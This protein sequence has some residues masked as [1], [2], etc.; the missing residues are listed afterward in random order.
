MPFAVIM[1]GCRPHRPNVARMG[2]RG[3]ATC[4]SDTRPAVEPAGDLDFPA[5]TG[6][7]PDDLAYWVALNAVR[8]ISSGAVWALRRA[9]DSMERAWG[10][11]AGELRRAGLES[12]VI[13]Q[14]LDARGDIEPEAALAA[15]EDSGGLAIAWDDPAYPAR[16]REIA[17]PPALLHVRGDVDALSQDRA[18]AIVGTRR[19]STY[20]RLVTERLAGD[21]AGSGITIVSGMASGV[22]SVAHRAALEAGGTTVAVWGTGLGTVYPVANRSLARQI[23]E[24]GAIVTEYPVWMRGSAENFPQ[25]NRIISG[26]V[27]GT[28]VV[29]APLPSGALITARYAI[30]HNREIM[31]VP[32]DIFKAGSQGTN[33]LIFRGEARAV[34][35]AADVLET[36]G[37]SVDP[38]QLALHPVVE[39]DADERPIADQLNAT[40]RHIDTMAQSAGLPAHRVSAILTMLELKGLAR[41]VGGG[42]YV[43]PRPEPAGQRD[44]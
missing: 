6:R 15:L 5:P 22:D 40:P 26:L 39:P 3:Y 34:T 44:G 20:A 41:H 4:V 1:A 29:E 33:A 19:M 16:L 13:K 7:T 9:F 2:R 28:I 18:V 17:D 35:S 14:F 32:G 38:V 25:R 24:Q 12:K 23:A 11:S 27:L 43:H 36:L 8:G 21:L 30:E 37:I 10:A 42:R 31:A